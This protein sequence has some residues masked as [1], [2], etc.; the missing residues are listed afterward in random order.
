MR[1]KFNNSFQNMTRSTL[2]YSNV[3]ALS[4]IFL[5]GLFSWSTVLLQILSIYN[6]REVIELN[7]VPAEIHEDILEE[8]VCKVLSLTGVNVAPIDLHACHHMKRSER[9]IVIF[10]LCKIF[11]VTNNEDLINFILINIPEPSLSIINIVF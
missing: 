1:N 3:K 9:I 11:H 7:P 4:L 8:S 10:K 5:P 2:S 6:R